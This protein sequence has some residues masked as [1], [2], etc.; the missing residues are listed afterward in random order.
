VG[1][2]LGLL[3]GGGFDG[4]VGTDRADERRPDCG[5][6]NGFVEVAETFS[7]GLR[8][9]REGTTPR[10]SGVRARVVLESRC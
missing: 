8:F 6:T 10:G 4:D 7:A 9:C 1:P 2:Q 5:K 3:L